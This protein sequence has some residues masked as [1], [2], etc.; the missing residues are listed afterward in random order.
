MLQREIRE[1]WM[2][3][4][5]PYFR[6]PHGVPQLDSWQALSGRRIQVFS[7]T[8]M[9]ILGGYNMISCG[10]HGDIAKDHWN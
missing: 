7:L 10:I 2:I 6:T 9:L 5:Y 8:G 3:W 4:G 1:E